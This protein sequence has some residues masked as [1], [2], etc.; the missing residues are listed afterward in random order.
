MF[1][2]WLYCGKFHNVP[3]EIRDRFFSK[4]RRVRGI[5]CVRIAINVAVED[6]IF[7]FKYMWDYREV[8]TALLVDGFLFGDHIQ[9]PGFRNEVIRH[10]FF[11][12]EVAEQVATLPEACFRVL[13]SPAISAQLQNLTVDVFIRSQLTKGDN[14]FE[15][16][17]RDKSG[18]STG[19][20]MDC[21]QRMF[22]LKA[23]DTDFRLAD[24][25]HRTCL[26]YH[27]HQG[28]MACCCASHSA[29]Q[30]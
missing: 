5:T 24:F 11:C 22:E 1:W 14:P 21:A 7:L 15:K 6:S 26:R 16:S 27:D 30:S 10:L 8:R 25:S 28:A 3:D 13:E 2:A 20:L 12:G 17:Q 19:F 18:V 29:E 9:S 4:D 23:Q